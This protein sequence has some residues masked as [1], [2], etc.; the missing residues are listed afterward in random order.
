MRLFFWL[1]SALVI[2]GWAVSRFLHPNGMNFPYD[3]FLFKYAGDIFFLNSAV[4]FF[5][6]PVLME[7]G[8]IGKDYHVE[9]DFGKA[10]FFMVVYT[11]VL[12][13]LVIVF[14]AAFFSGIRNLPFISIVILF[15][16]SYLK[17]CY[18]YFS[19]RTTGGVGNRK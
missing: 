14:S 11:I 19:K 1:I 5:I 7:K 8:I 9:S 6:I 17:N 10:K 18:V 13:G 3:F 15:C 12:P 4:L 2:I 16:Y